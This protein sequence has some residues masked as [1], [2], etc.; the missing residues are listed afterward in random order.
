MQPVTL[1]A[2]D[3]IGPEV[4]SAA[5]AIVEASRASVS[6][7]PVLAGQ[8]AEKATGTPLPAAVFDSIARTKLVLKGPTY[9]PFG[10]DYHYIR[11]G[12]DQST[13][14]LVDTGRD[15]QLGAKLDR[16]TGYT[17]IEKKSAADNLSSKDLPNRFSPSLPGR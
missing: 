11:T 12:T 16:L 6:F 1:I 4:T 8:E 15:K 10:G 14:L 13:Y 5:C 3:G 2:G 7:E 17:V 9:T